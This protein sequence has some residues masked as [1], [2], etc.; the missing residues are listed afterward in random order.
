MHKGVLLSTAMC[1]SSPVRSFKIWLRKERPSA[2]VRGTKLTRLSVRGLLDTLWYVA[3]TRMLRP[4]RREAK[5]H[6]TWVPQSLTLCL[7]KVFTSVAP[8]SSVREGDFSVVTTKEL[9]VR[10]GKWSFP[11][12]KAEKLD[13]DNPHHKLP[14]AEA[15]TAPPAEP[16]EVPVMADREEGGA[17]TSVR[18]TKRRRAMTRLRIAVRGWSPKCDGCRT[19]SYNHSASCRERFDALLDFHEPLARSEDVQRTEDE[20]L[21][22]D[23]RPPTE[24]EPPAFAGPA[25]G[26]SGT[27]VSSGVTACVDLLLSPECGLVDEGFA[28]KLCSG[29]P[30]DAA[31]CF[32]SN[33]ASRA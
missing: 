7:T 23:Y 12:A 25:A 30:R 27:E 15:F 26:G 8:L 3:R 19:G 13:E 10:N 21:E 31:F 28:Q 2:Q 18:M 24:P 22:T 4:S 1:R 17:E 11:L 32:A 29:L 9:A 33:H 6:C 14:L 16:G 20:A 5:P